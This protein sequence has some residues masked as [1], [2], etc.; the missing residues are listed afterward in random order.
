MLPAKMQ[1]MSMAT[2]NHFS[3]LSLV[4]IGL[5]DSSE[6]ELQAF[7]KE[8]ESREPRVYQEDV[9][10]VREILLMLSPILAGIAV[11]FWAMFWYFSISPEPVF[12]LLMLSIMLPFF[13]G[14]MV[15][16]LIVFRRESQARACGIGGISRTSL[17][18]S[19]LFLDMILN[20][21][22]EIGEL[23]DSTRLEEF[24][25]FDRTG[26]GRTIFT[27]RKLDLGEEYAQLIRQKMLTTV[28]GKQRL[29]VT[30]FPFAIVAV[31][32][33]MI[34][35]MIPQI[36]AV[37]SEEVA[38]IA[39]V[40]SI[41][42][43]TLLISGLAILIR[44]TG[45]PARRAEL[46]M[47]FAEPDLRSETR[48]VLERLLAV[49]LSECEYPLRIL[50]ISEYD[51]ITYTGTTYTTEKGINLREAILVPRRFSSLDYD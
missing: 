13:V 34:L 43:G 4:R 42:L 24:G 12:L 51:G 47:V 40:L 2:A 38:I 41:V 15:M 16:F 11:G 36:R 37:L 9:V 48:L 23:V 50:T 28:S 39:L 32:A 49:L 7:M 14:M 18:A 25:R 29:F 10:S 20:G 44:R 19:V 30:L 21:H 3:L 17:S 8:V 22:L 26:Y 31:T 6:D 46:E 1:E 35:M 33:M 45:A 27:L 5:N